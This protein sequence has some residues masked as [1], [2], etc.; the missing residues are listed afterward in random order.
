MIGPL[1]QIELFITTHSIQLRLQTM[2]EAYLV[3]V[4]FPNSHNPN[5]TITEKLH[6]YTDLKQKPLR[7]WPMNIAYIVIWYYPQRVL[8]Q[9]NTKP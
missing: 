9:K 1:Q 6:K 5:S 7:K 8:S 4:A 3:D 2:K